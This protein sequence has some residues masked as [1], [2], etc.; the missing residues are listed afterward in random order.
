GI[1]GGELKVH[2]ALQ[3]LPAGGANGERQ[4]VG[5]LDLE[6]FGCALEGL[7][8][9]PTTEADTCAS[10]GARRQA[11]I[12]G[13]QREEPRAIAQPGPPGKRMAAGYSILYFA[14][15]QIGVANELGGVGGCRAAV[16]F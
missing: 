8:Q 6:Q 15:Q 9:N 11:D 2:I 14:A 5:T 10:S 13:S 1:R 3:V 16:D 7:P 4:P 12:F